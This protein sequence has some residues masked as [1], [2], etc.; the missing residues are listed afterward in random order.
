MLGPFVVLNK[1]V[2]H[3]KRRGRGD[4]FTVTRCRRA[5]EVAKNVEEMDGRWKDHKMGGRRSR[6]NRP[7]RSVNAPSSVEWTPTGT[8]VARSSAGAPRTL[9]LPS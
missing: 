5:L 4:T 7:E 2:M 9:G 1:N 3:G 6:P 8:K